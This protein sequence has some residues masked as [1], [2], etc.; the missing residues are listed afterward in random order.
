M[1]T[2][3]GRKTEAMY[4]R[5]A[6]VDA[7]ALPDAAATIEVAAGNTGQPS[8]CARQRSAGLPTVALGR[9]QGKSA[10]ASL[11]HA[12]AENLRALTGELRSPP[13]RPCILT[14]STSTTVS[15]ARRGGSPQRPGSRDR[16]V[17]GRQRLRQGRPAL[18]R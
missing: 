9:Y 12:M 15:T 7:G 16:C 11:P 1:S 5:Y 10:V 3:A 2:M 6:I 4:R 18:L 17:A 13:S 14:N 8:R